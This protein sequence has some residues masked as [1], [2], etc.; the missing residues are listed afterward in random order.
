[1]VIAT[2]GEVVADYR[3]RMTLDPARVAEMAGITEAQYRAL[4]TGAAWPGSAAVQAVIDVLRIPHDKRLNLMPTHS[5]LDPCLSQILHGY[6]LPALIVDSEWRAVESNSYAQRLLPGSAQPGW[7][8]PRWILQ[9]AEAR[10]RLANWRH[11]VH[12][13]ADLI[14]DELA[15][16]LDSR[17]LHDLA[18]ASRQYCTGSDSHHEGHSAGHILTWRTAAGPFPTTACLISVPTG[19]P[20]LRQV[21][22]IPRGTQ[23]GHSLLDANPSQA[24]NG[25]LLLD[26]LSCGLCGL[27][28]TG[29]GAPETY[30]CATGC[31]PPL[32]AS[33]L[34]T[35]V[36]EEVVPRV[37]DPDECRQLAVAQESLTADGF[38][39]NLNVPVTGKHAL[40]QWSRSMTDTQRRG[41]LSSA[42]RSITVYGS[43]DGR[44]WE[45]SAL[46]YTWRELV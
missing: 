14:R 10:E 7:S 45:K 31:L 4:E 13:I 44:S 8:L 19:R 29:G 11:V 5:P 34:E 30:H 6:D 27:L 12:V 26:L 39:M 15:A 36:A 42:L 24:W 16:G 37:F 18:R 41:I 1:M 32:P 9:S 35:R 46:R 3:T 17:E 33:T 2:L 21:T 43:N 22:L 25:P 40:H 20:D 38:N 28:L 23:P